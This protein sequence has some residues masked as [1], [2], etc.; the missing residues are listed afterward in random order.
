MNNQRTWKF[1]D[2][3]DL[4]PNSVGHLSIVVRDVPLIPKSRSLVNFSYQ[5]ICVHFHLILHPFINYFFRGNRKNVS[6]KTA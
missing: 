3:G 6:A 5:A 1:K 4:H 2:R